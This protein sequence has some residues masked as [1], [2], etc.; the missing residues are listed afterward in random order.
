MKGLDERKEEGGRDERA[1]RW[2]IKKFHTLL[3]S[4]IGRLYVI[5]VLGCLCIFIWKMLNACNYCYYCSSLEVLKR[6]V[7]L[8][9]FSA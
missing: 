3:Y 1:E 8:T 4:F 2:N 9:E 7:I 6:R 5:V